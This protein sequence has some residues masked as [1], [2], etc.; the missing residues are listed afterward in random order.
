MCSSTL[1]FI[2]PIYYSLHLLIQ[3][4]NSSLPHSSSHLANITLFSIS[5]CFT[6]WFWNVDIF[7]YQFPRLKRLPLGSQLN[8]AGAD[9]IPGA[10]SAAWPEVDSHLPGSWVGVDHSLF[11]GRWG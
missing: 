9:H 7:S 3:A 4:P 10:G 2:I 8:G 11:S 5:E 6:N 1:L